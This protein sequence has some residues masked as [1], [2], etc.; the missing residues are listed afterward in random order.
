MNQK[1]DEFFEKVITVKLPQDRSYVDIIDQTLLPGTIRRI[2]LDTREE[3][4]EAIKKLRVRGAPAIGVCAAYGMA[5]LANKYKAADYDAFYAQ[6]KSDKDYLATSRPT[7][8]NLFWALDRMVRTCQANA[9]RPLDELKEILFTEAQAIRDE[10]VQISRNIGEIGFGLLKNLKED[11]KELGIMT[12]CN[13]GTLATAKY[14]TAT[15]PMYIALEH[16]WEGSDMHV[17]CDETRPLLQGARLTSFELYNAGITT[18]VQCDNMASLLM[19][20]GR[21]K[22]IFVGCDR[23]AANGDAANKIGT[24]GLA[25]IAKHYGVPFY[26]CAPSSTIDPKT[27]TGDQ[28]P[29][30]MRDPEEIKTMWYKEPMA[31]EGVDASFNPAFDV[32]DH[33]LITGIITEKGLC[34]GPDYGA[35]FKK[36]GLI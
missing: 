28:I 29:I 26:V 3:I 22:I 6:F 20:S 35:E 12:H 16:G 19:K 1:L 9:F 36:L 24:S 2:K 17:Y 25:I 30:E 32:T 27:P 4:W 18:S 23:V 34:T 14:G 15:A 10:D 21:V 5:V 13:A 7:A 33:S 8:V 11:G 31:P